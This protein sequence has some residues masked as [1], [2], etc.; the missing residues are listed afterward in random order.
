[1]VGAGEGWLLGLGLATAG[2]AVA[3]S[4]PTRATLLLATGTV[5]MFAY[6][7]ALVVRYFGDTLGMPVA[8]GCAGLL[9]LGLAVGVGRLSQRTPRPPGA[10]GSAS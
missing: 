4:I 9:I 2:V 10:I 6:V 8:L 3:A 5:A 7:T 1:M